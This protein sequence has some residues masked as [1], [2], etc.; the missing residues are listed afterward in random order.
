MPVLGEDHG[1]A[2]NSPIHPKSLQQSVRII[3]ILRGQPFYIL[4]GGGSMGG[5]IF[6]LMQARIFLD[7]QGHLS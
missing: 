2:L 4:A 7:I 3:K 1:S 6:L 5:Y